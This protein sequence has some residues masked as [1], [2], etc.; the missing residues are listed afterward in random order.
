[1]PSR[2]PLWIKLVFT[3]WVAV[4]ATSYFVKL[5]WQNFLWL[6]D[7]ASFLILVA[8]WC[9]NRLLMSAQLLAVFVVGVFWALDVGS[10]LLIGVHPIGGTEYMFNAEMPLYFRLLSLF[11]L[12]LPLVAAYGVWKLGYD[13]RGLWLQTALTWIVLPLSLAFTEPERNINWV[14]GPFGRP[15]ETLDP[16]MYLLGLMLIWPIALY[17]PTHGLM[18]LKRFLPGRR[19]R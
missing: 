13:R 12:F 8:L 7:L 10:A 15:Q 17:L 5:G 3:L 6:C 18:M 11:H 9:E 16:L 1:M 19:P 2:L 14:Q 4:W